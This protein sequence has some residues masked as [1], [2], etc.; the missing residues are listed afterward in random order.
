M[1]HRTTIGEF[2]QTILN[3]TK[4]ILQLFTNYK[5][6]TLKNGTASY[7]ESAELVTNHPVMISIQPPRYTS[8]PFIINI[9]SSVIS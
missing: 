3:V 2:A 7:N 1:H 9:L 5:Q 6:D 8:S 4:K